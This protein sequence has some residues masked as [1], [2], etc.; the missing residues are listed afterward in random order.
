MHISQCKEPH[1]T[2]LRWDSQWPSIFSL[3]LDDNLLRKERALRGQNRKEE[4]KENYVTA[5]N[6]HC[7]WNRI[8]RTTC[9]KASHQPN[10]YCLP[11]VSTNQPCWKGEGTAGGAL[12]P[13]TQ[14]WGRCEPS[15]PAQLPNEWSWV[16]DPGYYNKGKNCPAEP[17]LNSWSSEL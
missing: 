11:L 6:S 14:A 3:N 8:W 15:R 1:P 13:Q 10:F 17:F 9:L 2:H 7:E 16:S 5:Q 12:K 4:N